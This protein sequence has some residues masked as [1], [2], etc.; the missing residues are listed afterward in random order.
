VT[1]MPSTFRTVILLTAY[2]TVD[3]AVEAMKHGA[4]EIVCLTISSAMSGTYSLAE[5]V[6]KQVE[7][8]VHVVD[9]KGPT[10]SLGWQ[11]LAA[12][13]CRE[14]GGKALD[15]IAAAA[16]ARLKMVQV[17]CLDTLEYLQRGGRIGMA[18]RFIGSLLNLKPLVKI[19]HKTG[20]VEASG[21]ARTRKKSIE[22]LE[23]RFFEEI[24]PDK[25]LHLAVLH[26]DAP[27]EA[28]DLAEHIRKERSPKELLINMTGP[29]LGIHTGPS[30]LA[31]CGYTEE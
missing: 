15:M 3:M 20:L 21:Q 18:T 28:A 4:Q 1:S 24:D 29:V 25:P 2:S 14:A 16:Q 17:V 5:Q 30:A 23:E 26:G 6:G 31:L 13:R 7:V 22:V 9:S 27:E 19:N 8:P 12:A 11:V 10:M